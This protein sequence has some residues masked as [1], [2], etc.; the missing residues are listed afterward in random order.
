LDCRAIEVG[1]EKEEEAAEEEAE[2]DGAES[3]SS[4]KLFF[5]LFIKEII[6]RCRKNRKFG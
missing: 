4:N 5:S 1:E 3:V 2:E 6:I